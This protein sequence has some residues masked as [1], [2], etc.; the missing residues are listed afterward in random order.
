MLLIENVRHRIEE[1]EKD[2]FPQVREGLGR[3]QLQEIGA[4]MAE[5]KA[6]AP[7]TPAAPSAL[8]GGSRH[9]RTI[10]CAQAR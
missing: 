9:V 10:R 8:I 1:E 2:W 7:R 6:R 4:E 5:A 3:K